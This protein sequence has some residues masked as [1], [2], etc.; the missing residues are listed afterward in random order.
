M[1]G[2][3]TDLYDTSTM[4]EFIH[5]KDRSTHIGLLGAMNNHKGFGGED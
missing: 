2:A 5:I 4:Y 3:F 1:S